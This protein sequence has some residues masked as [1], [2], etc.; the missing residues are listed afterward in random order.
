MATF[1]LHKHFK[2]YFG[3]QHYKYQVIMLHI[4][5]T[6]QIITVHSSLLTSILLPSSS[7]THSRTHVHTHTPRV[8]AHNV[9]GTTICRLYGTYCQQ[10]SEENIKLSDDND[11]DDDDI[12]MMIT[13]IFIKTC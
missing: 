8:V 10:L 11:D 13:I 6:S 2:Q 4:F 3:S 1:V 9:V 5:Q 7:R 12:I